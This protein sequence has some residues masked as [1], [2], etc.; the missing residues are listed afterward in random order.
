MN[1]LYALPI[2]L[3]LCH[4]LFAEEIENSSLSSKTH[5]EE[6][7]AYAVE[8]DKA[9]SDAE[10]EEEE[11]VSTVQEAA[12][13]PQVR[14]FTTMPS[15]VPNPYLQRN[16]ADAEVKPL[17]PQ[18]PLSPRAR[19]QMRQDKAAKAQSPQAAQPAPS[20]QGPVAPK[21]AAPRTRQPTPSQ[22]QV[23]PKQT[24]P[25]RKPDVQVQAPPARQQNATSAPRSTQA[26]VT[27]SKRAPS[28]SPR[29]EQPK[30]V[31]VAPAAAPQSTTPPAPTTAAQKS[32]NKMAGKMYNTATRPVLKN[33]YNLWLVGD[34]LLW[35]AVEENLTYV[36]SGSDSSR[37]LH[38]VDFDWDWGFRVGAGYNAPRD[39][40]DFDLYWT[41][42]RN[43]AHDTQHAHED[44]QL[45]QVWSVANNLFPGIINEAKAHW[46]VNLEQVDLELGRQFFVGQY[47]TIRPFA[48]LRSAWIF[49]KYNTELEG[50]DL[51]NVAFE[52]EAKLRNKFWGFGFVAGLDSDWRLGKG[53]SIYADADMSILMGYFDIDQK[54]TLNE[55][56]IWSQDKSFRTGRAILDLG[57][58]L[59]WATLFCGD[60]LGLTF[61]AGYEYHLYFNQNQ[62]V[63][64]SGNSD[65]ELF[66][67]VKGDLTYQGV[68]GSIQFDF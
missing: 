64:S 11:V 15:Q 5:V 39:G 19:S 35:Q 66:N 18:K 27:P 6:E 55:V 21:Q 14:R 45:Y 67:P 65:F 7:I 3:F 31:A 37:N 28:V 1:K 26:Q 53:F 58:G 48:G 59:Q 46:H 34:A 38:T 33:G 10:E 25:Q 57:L 36:Y 2:S 29:A 63:L 49:Q 32:Q 24:T 42:I 8:E 9:F 40:W 43:T 13:A 20:Q 68:I 44:R 22:G 41:H 52:Q 17:A 54:A 4:P 56:T 47:L 12:P 30:K 61:K 50:P 60:R 51:L 62:F 23:A 16:I